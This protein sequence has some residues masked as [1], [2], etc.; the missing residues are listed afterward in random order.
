MLSHAA[1]PLFPQTIGSE[2]N[3]G[4]AD[5][6]VIKNYGWKRVTIFQLDVDSFENVRL[7]CVGGYRLKLPPPRQ[8][9]A[10]PTKCCTHGCNLAVIVP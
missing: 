6:G 3:Q 2:E 8:G 10:T 4:F 9:R 7:L 5:F 1:F